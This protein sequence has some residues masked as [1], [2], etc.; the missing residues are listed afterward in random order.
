MLAHE[1]LM[2]RGWDSAST[3]SEGSSRLSPGDIRRAQVGTTRLVDN[4]FFYVGSRLFLIS[5]IDADNA[6]GRKRGAPVPSTASIQPYGS[7]PQSP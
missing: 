3:S 5:L 4:K 1:Q 7:Q 2:A 6:S